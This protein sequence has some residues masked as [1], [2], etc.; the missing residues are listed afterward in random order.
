MYRAGHEATDHVGRSGRIQCRGRAS[1][2]R[3]QVAPQ[4]EGK[5]MSQ[6]SPIWRTISQLTWCTV[7][8]AA[9]PTTEDATTWL[10]EGALSSER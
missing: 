8:P 1:A 2:R 4:P 3:E 7:A 5:V 6:A 9:V 10:V